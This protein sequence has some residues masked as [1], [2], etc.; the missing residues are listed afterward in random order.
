MRN[1]LIVLAY[2]SALPLGVLG[3]LVMAIW[4]SETHEFGPW[5]PRYLLLAYGSDVARLDLVEPVSGSVRYTANGRAGTAPARVIA[6]FKT[7]VPAEQVIE[8]YQKRCAEIGLVAQSMPPEKRE[9]A[10]RCDGDKSELGIQARQFD[11]IT[12]VTVGGWIGKG[13]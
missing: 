11:D 13:H 6:S 1:P 9:P 8:I 7:R 2:I 10:L 3:V 12:D 4:L 5:D